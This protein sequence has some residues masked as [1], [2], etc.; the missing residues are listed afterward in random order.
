MITAR[1]GTIERVN[2]AM[3]DMTGYTA[4]ELIGMDSSSLPIPTSASTAP[5]SSTRC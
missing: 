3:C 1:D 4:D 2:Q 5:P